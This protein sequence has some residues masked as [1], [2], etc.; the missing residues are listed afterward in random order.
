VETLYSTK[1]QAKL[2]KDFLFCDHVTSGMSGGICASK[3]A[4]INTKK[5]EIEFEKLVFKWTETQ[6]GQFAELRKVAN[7]FF[8]EHAREELDLSGTAR[9][10]IA[11]Q[12][13][14]MLQGEFIQSFK[15]FEE[16]ALPNDTDFKKADA[17]LNRVYSRLMKQKVTEGTT[18]TK[19]GIKGTQRKWLKFRDAWTKFALAKYPTTCANGWNTWMTQKRIEQLKTFDDWY[20]DND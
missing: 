13:E 5:R 20:R 4:D 18:V 1:D 3:N 2:K 19:A 14:E 7:Q 6:K 9:A 17:E 15:A 10:Q 16:G 12:E 11:I 8:S